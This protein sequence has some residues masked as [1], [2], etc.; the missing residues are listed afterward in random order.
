MAYIVQTTNRAEFVAVNGL[1]TA[2]KIVCD[3]NE[4][5][6][7]WYESLANAGEAAATR[8]N[9]QN[10]Q[11]YKAAREAFE[12]LESYLKAQFGPKPW[13]RSTLLRIET[14]LDNIGTTKGL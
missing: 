6:T 14:V 11:D 10:L 7:F 9:V 3:D 5:A 2:V 13:F 4:V 12:N 1:N 8:D